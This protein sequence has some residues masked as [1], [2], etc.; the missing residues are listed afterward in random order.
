MT[1][2]QST[3][4]VISGDVQGVLFRRNAKIEADK[5]AINGWIRNNIEGSVEV[6]AQGGKSELEKF[7]SWCKIGPP[8]AN[9]KKI[10][11]IGVI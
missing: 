6:L 9:V 1:K 11:L 10:E 5:L 4:I 2:L 3:R 8:L 7:I